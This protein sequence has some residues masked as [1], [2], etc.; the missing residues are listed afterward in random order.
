MVPDPQTIQKRLVEFRARAGTEEGSQ[1]AV[2]LGEIHDPVVE[3][4]ALELA[5]S[6]SLEQRLAGLDLLDRLDIENPITQGA[7]LEILRTDGRTEII[8]A[9][10]YAL[11]RGVPNPRET[12][13]VIQTLLPF[14]AHP[15]PEVRR[16]CVI[17]LSEWGEPSIALQALQ[18]SS[19][20]VRAGAAFALG[21]VRHAVPGMVDSLATCVANDH[22]DWAV[23]EQAWRVL[24]TFPLDERTYAVYSQFKE[25]HQA[26][27]EATPPD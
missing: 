11:H 20:D 4:A 16:R 13:N 17:A 25:A 15:D 19:P 3:E 24:A 2:I 18:D 26:M 21:Q 1:L 5:Q 8:H 7:I 27:G 22:E 6:G 9:A 12:A 10:L 14:A 23:R